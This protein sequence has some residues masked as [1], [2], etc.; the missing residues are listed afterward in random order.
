MGA[1]SFL[2][3]PTIKYNVNVTRGGITQT[4]TVYPKEDFYQIQLTSGNYTQPQNVASNYNSASYDVL[5]MTEPDVYHI[6]F[7]LFYY[8]AGANTDSLMFWVK[9]ET[10]QTYMN[11]QNVTIPSLKGPVLLN[12]TVANE[13]GMQWRW[14][15]DAHHPS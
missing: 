1:I 15:Y 8:D 11:W 4:T 12:Y 10:N 14:G 2:M 13:I 3:L 5:N 9:C 6:K 7:Q